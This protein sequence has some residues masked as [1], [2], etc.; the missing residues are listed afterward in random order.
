M[1]CLSC[2][3]QKKVRRETG[4][5]DEEIREDEDDAQD[6]KDCGVEFEDVAHLQLD[7]LMGSKQSKRP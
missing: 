6:G 7:P 4:D 5:G 2:A 3:H 1:K